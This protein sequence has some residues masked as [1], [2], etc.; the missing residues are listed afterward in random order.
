MRIGLDRVSF[1]GAGLHRPECVLAT[2]GGRVFASDWDG[3]VAAVSPDGTVTRYLARAGPELKPNGIALRPDGSFLIA[4]LGADRG[5]VFH[6]R[7][8]GALAPLITEVEGTALP[9]TNFVLETEGGRVWASV[10]TRLVPRDLGYRRDN[11]D[12]FI[13]VADAQ[14][15]RVAADGLGYANEIALDPGGGWLYVNETFARRLSRFAL[16]AGGAL[17]PRETVTEFG[18]GVFPDGLAFDREGAAWIVSIVS[19]RVVRVLPG[20]A[21]ETVLDD[22]D[23]AHLAWVEA[24]YADGGLGREHLDTLKSKRLRNV[25]SLAFGGP[26]LKTVYLGCLLGGEIATF[27]SPIAGRPPAHWAYER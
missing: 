27:R 9:P 26:D 19:N 13:V 17:G 8:D 16:R 11:A 25:S 15:A 14:G 6:L 7:R 24:A 4:H 21:Q 2:A 22:S 12:G 18:A 3:G 20:G 5:G 10:S 1:L 23:P